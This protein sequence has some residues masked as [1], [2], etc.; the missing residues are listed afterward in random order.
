M[1]HA[2]GL[3]RRA[4]EAGEV[5]VGA[6]VVRGGAVLA[7]GWNRPI[8]EHDASAHAEIVALRAAGARVGNY[9]F[10]ATTLYVTLEPCMMCAGALVHARVERM[11]FGAFDP[12]SGAVGSVWN[13]LDAPGLNHRVQWQGGVLAADCGALLQNFFAA[14]RQ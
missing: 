14:R 8:A 12:K 10:P 6:V 1:R 5:P 9:R 3:A 4:A 13:A 2:L 7:E 11:V